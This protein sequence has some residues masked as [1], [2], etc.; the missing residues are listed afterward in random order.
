MGLDTFAARLKGET[1]FLSDDDKDAFA[2]ANF[3]LCHGMLAAGPWSFRGKVYNLLVA[4]ITGKSLY[5]DYI[6]PRDVAD[7]ATKLG[8][9]DAKSI[10]DLSDRHS[11]SVD[12]IRDLIKFFAIC[13]ERGLGL[14]GWW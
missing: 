10:A 1:V 6:S 3:K 11:L 2:K 12:E 7:M 13:A 5:Q 8:L 14:A 4:E 9:L